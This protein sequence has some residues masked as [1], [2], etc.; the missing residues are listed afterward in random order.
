MT[1][2]TNSRYYKTGMIISCIIAGIGAFNWLLT[3]YNINLVQS[4]VKNQTAQKVIY[5]IIGLCGVITI[6]GAIQWSKKRMIYDSETGQKIENF[7]R[8]EGCCNQK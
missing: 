4:L 6:I 3:N 8:R 7:R 2:I 5:F 1:K